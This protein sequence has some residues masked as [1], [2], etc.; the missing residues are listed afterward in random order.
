MAETVFHHHLF[1]TSIRLFL[2]APKAMFDDLTL[3]QTGEKNN[4]KTAKQQLKSSV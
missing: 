4:Q 1:I 2:T 3:S